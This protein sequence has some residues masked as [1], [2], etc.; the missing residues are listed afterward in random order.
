MELRK[1][2]RILSQT[3]FIRV[4]NWPAKLAISPRSSP[5]NVLRGEVTGETAVFAGLLLD[6]TKYYVK[7]TRLQRSVGGTIYHMCYKYSS[8][9]FYKIT[10]IVRALIGREA[11]LHER[12]VNVVVT[13][14]CFAFRALITQAR[15]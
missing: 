14:R 11:C 8:I 2:L 9:V 1:G 13:S 5:Q 15:I 7:G 4:I 10:Q 12:Y 6:N 3:N